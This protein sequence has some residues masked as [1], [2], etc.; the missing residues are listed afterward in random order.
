MQESDLM[1]GRGRTSRIGEGQGG[2]KEISYEL[3]G[4]WAEQEKKLEA[5]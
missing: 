3:E 2:K 1:G 5:S 4:Y